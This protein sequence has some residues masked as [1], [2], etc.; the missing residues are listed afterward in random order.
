MGSAL[1]MPSPVESPFPVPVS[2]S[3]SQYSLP[4]AAID[5]WEGSVPHPY[6]WLAKMLTAFQ[7]AASFLMALK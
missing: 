5:G 6:S 3:V 7:A 1:A 4:A 2:T